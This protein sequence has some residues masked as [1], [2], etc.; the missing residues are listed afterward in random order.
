MNKTIKVHKEAVKL[1]LEISQY[2]SFL[3]SI[4]PDKL[5]PLTADCARPEIISHLR[6][7]GYH[8]FPSVKGAGSVK[9]GIT[10][11]QDHEIIVDYSCENTIKALERY[12]YKVDKQSGRITDIP[13]HD[14]SD[15]VDALKYALEAHQRHQRG[16][17]NHTA[18]IPPPRII[19]K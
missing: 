19:W 8:I 18:L 6:S 11:L 9:A 17:K 10:F 3:S 16:V 15:C 2:D 1:R 14:H 13:H 12:S 7:L 5:I 4:I